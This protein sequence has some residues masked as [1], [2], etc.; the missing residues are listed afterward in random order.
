M[1]GKRLKL[2]SHS[3][4]DNKGNDEAKLEIDLVSRFAEEWKKGENCKSSNLTSLQNGLR[5]ERILMTFHKHIAERRNINCLRMLTNGIP[6]IIST[7]WQLFRR[8]HWKVKKKL[9]GNGGCEDKGFWRKVDFKISWTMR[10]ILMWI[11]KIA[12]GI[13]TPTV[14]SVN[15]KYCH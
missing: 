12:S 14:T 11:S 2:V 1:N 8:K 5:S 9:C 7:S 4:R 15:R 6:F 10:K 3:F 13:P